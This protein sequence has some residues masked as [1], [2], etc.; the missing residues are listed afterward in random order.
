M[1][2]VA[3]RTSAIQA[4]GATRLRSNAVCAMPRLPAMKMQM[5]MRP[6]EV[7]SPFANAPIRAKIIANA[8]A[9]TGAF[10][11]GFDSD[12]Q[13]FVYLCR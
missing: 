10:L 2:T 5:R 4:A 8:A 3:L 6:V 7:A 1:A 12:A 11:G 9:G 13:V